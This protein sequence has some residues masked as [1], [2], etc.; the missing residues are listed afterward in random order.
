MKTRSLLLSIATLLGVSFLQ[1]QETN[2]SPLYLNVS[3]G[4]STTTWD[5]VEDGFGVGLAFGTIIKER[6]YIEAELMYLKNDIEGYSDTISGVH[7]NISPEL[8]QLPVLATY[9]YSIPLGADTGWSLQVGG[10]VG[11]VMQKLKI[12][13]SGSMGGTHV[14]VSESE[15]K[16]AAALGAQALAVYK[17]NQTTSVN[18]GLKAIWTA[19]TDLNDEAGTNM[20]F[21]AGVRFRF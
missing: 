6:H 16:W 8:Q 15:S 11:A 18:A 17:I 7:V 19:E 9:R 13:A 1:A 10:S 4:Y 14:T 21:T 5:N 2:R 12:S 3:A 20:M